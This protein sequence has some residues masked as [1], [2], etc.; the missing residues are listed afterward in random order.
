MDKEF[1]ALFL[2]VDQWMRKPVIFATADT[3]RTGILE[4]IKV[5]STLWTGSKPIEAKIAILN[6]R[7]PTNKPEYGVVDR[8]LW[9]LQCDFD[10][11]ESKLE[12]T[13]LG[14]VY[15][16]SGTIT[17]LVIINGKPEELN[18]G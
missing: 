17:G 18:L 12:R 6:V 5:L 16:K 2:D 13:V 1:I 7:V 3:R 4:H 11:P 14:N 15:F 8:S 9:Q 10:Q